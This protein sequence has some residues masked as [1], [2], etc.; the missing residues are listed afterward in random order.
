MNR[1]FIVVFFCSF[2]FVVNA[3]TSVTDSVITGKVTIIKDSRLD[4]LVIKE[5]TFN[6][7]IALAPKTSKGYRLMVLNSNNR[8]LSMQI[9]SQLLQ[10]YPDE[11]LYMSFQ[12]PY[13]KLKMGNFVS[14]EEAENFKKDII[15]N[16]KITSNIYILSETIE[17]KPE[18]EMAVP[19]K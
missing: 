5:A 17:L 13:V 14:K 12:S 9:R 15:K 6:E 2:G 11:K 19:I 1:F 4:D 3:Q 8:D 16:L 7:A 10:R 18:N